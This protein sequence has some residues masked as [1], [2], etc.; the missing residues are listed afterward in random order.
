MRPQTTKVSTGIRNSTTQ[1]GAGYS[2]RCSANAASQLAE[3]V[4]SDDDLPIRRLPQCLIIGVRKGGTRA[5][6]EFLNLHPDV[7]AERSEVHFFDRD[8][9]YKRGLDWYRHQMRASH[10]GWQACDY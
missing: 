2:S 4:Y 9:R 6:L 3:N 7:Q 10:T 5:L 8:N 1:D